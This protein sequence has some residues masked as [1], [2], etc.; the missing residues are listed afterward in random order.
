VKTRVRNTF[1]DGWSYIANSVMGSPTTKIYFRA[2]KD[3]IV[4]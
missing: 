4:W 3:R 1:D 2:N